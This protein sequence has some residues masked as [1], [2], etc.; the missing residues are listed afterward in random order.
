MSET[1][2]EQA[3][4]RFVGIDLGTT[5]SAVAWTGPSGR[6]AIRIVDLFQ[7]VAPGEVGRFPALPSFLYLPQD[8][9]IAAGAVAQPWVPQLPAGS[10]PVVTAIAGVFARDHGSLAPGRLVASTKSWLANPS[11]DRTMPLLPWGVEG[12]PR[13][14][15]VDASAR[16]L[17]H[18][19]DAWDYAFARDD[20]GLRLASQPIVLTVPAS[21]DEEARELT[22]EAARA[23]GVLNLRLLEEPLAALY[24]WIARNRR[25]AQSRLG[26]GAFVLVCDVGGGTADFSLIRTFEENGDLRFERIAIGE[27]LLLGGDNLDLALAALVERKLTTAGAARLTLTQR[28]ILLRKCCGA[29]ERL[30]SAGAPPEETIT[31]LG[32][33]R[34]LIA[35][36]MSTTLTR[37]GSYVRPYTPHARCS[38]ANFVRGE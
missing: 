37:D 10:D 36:G 7:L 2:T 25:Q 30:L 17:A 14:S 6:Q 31:I 9:E 28:Q 16:L 5:N 4:S 21:F 8:S 22:V 23:A 11:V 33:G 34:G 18:I 20:E 29:K 19:R 15:P 24:A 12:G 13:L 27:H 3:P 35:G 38:I 32:A 26:V 1:R